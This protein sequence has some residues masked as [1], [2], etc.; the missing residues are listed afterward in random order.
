MGFWSSVS[1]FVSSACSAIGSVASKIGSGI[2]NV[3]TSIASLGVTLAAKVGEAIKNVGISLG[4]IRPED[5]MEELGEK[6]MLSEKTPE[7][8]DSISEYIDHLRND[9]VIDKEKFDSLS[10]AEKL[11]RSSIGA[12]ITLKG[13]N[14]K[15][16]TVVSPAFMATV[17][18]Q[19]LEAKEIIGTIKAYKEKN[20]NTDDYS[21]Y[22]KD[23]LSIDE[24]HKHG[25]ALVEAY[26]KLEPEL[27]TEQIEDKVM[28][29]KS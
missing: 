29:L 13:I 28:E 18:A 22:L 3:A 16:D 6:A 1:S 4:I 25:S 10:D 23:E 21:L 2:A 5:N 17:A 27:T 24:S 11:A 19:D 8:F 20:L 14:E 9:V 7:D 12:S 15:L 26:Q